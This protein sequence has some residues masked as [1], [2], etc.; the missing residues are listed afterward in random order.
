MTKSSLFKL[1]M[2]S[3][4][5]TTWEERRTK[6]QTVDDRLQ[7]IKE[8]HSKAQDCIKHTVRS[9]VHVSPKRSGFRGG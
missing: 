9:R 5:Q 2:G 1:L 7:D 8:A 4:P 3:E 6:V